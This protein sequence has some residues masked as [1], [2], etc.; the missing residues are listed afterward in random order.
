VKRDTERL[1]DEMERLERGAP[2]N[3]SGSG[4]LREAEGDMEAS[5]KKLE[6][7]AREQA[8]PHAEAAR[9]KL[10]RAYKEFEEFEEK[11]KKLTQLPDYEKLAE[12]QDDTAEQT[13]KLL[14]EMPQADP[15]AANPQGTPGREGVEGAKKAMDRASRNLRGRSAKGA[16]S[17]QKE[18]VERLEKAREELEEALRQM[19]EEEQLM[20]LDAIERRLVRMLRAQT[21]L[22]KRTI[23]LHLRIRN[24][25]EPGRNERDLAG[26]LADGEAEIAGEADKLLALLQEE[27]STIVIPD[28]VA[29][30]RGDL[31]GLA[32]RL[33]GFDAGPYT[34]QIQQDVIETLK[35]L[36]EV[37]QEEQQRRQGNQQQG[38]GQDPMEGDQ[39]E[40]LLPT[41]A[42]LK[43]LKSLQ[44][45]VNRRTEQFDRMEGKDDAERDRL[46]EKQSAVGDLTR[47]MADK[48][49]REEE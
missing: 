36:I 42:E 8:Q 20:L 47:T 31:D 14:D 29:D 7:G 37:V 35:E 9:E 44:V 27:G 46:S 2:G 10:E 33:R 6:R 49:N 5:R 19:R 12:E 32:G 17:D 1:R 18:A 21:D 34:Q 38:Q 48:L 28:V 26:Q 16:N 24:Q 41:S 22:Y 13:Q 39:E 25:P 3:D 40:N 43:M 30:L 15:E 11:L 4:N 45:R 23:S